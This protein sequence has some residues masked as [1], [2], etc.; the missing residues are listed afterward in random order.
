MPHATERA[1]IIIDVDNT[2][3]TLLDR[4]IRAAA[5]FVRNPACWL[6]RLENLTDE[7]RPGDARK[8]RFLTRKAY[9]N[10][11]GRI[12]VPGEVRERPIGEFRSAFVQAGFEV[13]DTPPLTK[14][15]KTATDM[16]IALDTYE[17][18]A[19]APIDAFFILSSDADFTPL[20]ARIRARDRRIVVVATGYAAAAYRAAADIFIDYSRFSTV[21]GVVSPSAIL[22]AATEAIAE[23]HGAVRVGTIAESIIAKLGHDVATDEWCGYGNLADFIEKFGGNALQVIHSPVG[24]WIIASANAHCSGTKSSARHRPRK[25]PSLAIGSTLFRPSPAAVSEPIQPPV[26]HPRPGPS[27]ASK[28]D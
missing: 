11:V 21:L 19:S 14:G 20:L 9:L 1:A 17:M 27:T 8:Y 12:L 22:S 24:D 13:V 2:L 26:N 4:D 10:P 15:G 5:N 25:A 3:G 7:G 6:Q 28:G 16:I 23:L 18:L